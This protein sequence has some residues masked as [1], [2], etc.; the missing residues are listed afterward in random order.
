RQLETDRAVG[1]SWLVTKG[2]A[3]GEQ[4]VIEGLQKVRPGATVKA[5]PATFGKQAGSAAPA[6]SGS[7]APR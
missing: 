5:V 1:D 3:A 6:G 7:G 2:L 4:I